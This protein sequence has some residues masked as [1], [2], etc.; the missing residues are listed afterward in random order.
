VTNIEDGTIPDDL[1]S[2]A[3]YGEKGQPLRVEDEQIWKTN[4]SFFYLRL[5]TPSRDQIP[6]DSRLK[7][8]WQ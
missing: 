7:I 6:P 8:W 1:P 4:T 2:V 5:A 3:L